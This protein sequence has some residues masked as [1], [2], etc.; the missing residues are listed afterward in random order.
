M[1]SNIQDD[2]MIDGLGGQGETASASETTHISINLDVL[3]AM[4]EKPLS[5]TA[6]FVAYG[7]SAVEISDTTEI[8]LPRAIIAMG[9][10]GSSDTELR[11]VFSTG[12]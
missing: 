12:W 7:L 5:E 4:A 9:E 11:S 6:K 3:L 2:K 10:S 8:R 1:E